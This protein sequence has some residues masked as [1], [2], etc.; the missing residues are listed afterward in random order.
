MEQ[1]RRKGQTDDPSYRLILE[2]E[3]GFVADYYG[4]QKW[5]SKED[6]EVVGDPCST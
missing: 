2:M 4:L 1:V 3:Y 6:Y 5:F